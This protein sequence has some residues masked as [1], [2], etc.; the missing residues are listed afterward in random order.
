M[1]DEEPEILSF[2]LGDKQFAVTLYD[3]GYLDEVVGDPPGFG[4]RE[5]LFAAVRE[6]VEFP[7]GDELPWNYRIDNLLFEEDEYHKWS[8]DIAGM[9][10]ASDANYAHEA[11][12][13]RHFN[14]PNPEIT[15]LDI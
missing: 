9:I 10:P 5:E 13:Y 3:S 4:T 2:Y 11:G 1:S 12:P 15:Q 7:D 6:N 14:N 8:I